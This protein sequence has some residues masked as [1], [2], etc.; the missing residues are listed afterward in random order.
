MSGWVWHREKTFNVD[1]LTV[2]RSACVSVYIGML[3]TIITSYK[4]TTNVHSY[5]LEYS[6]YPVDNA[7]Y[8]MMKFWE[9]LLTPAQ[10]VACL[11]APGLVK[12]F[13]D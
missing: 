7:Y 3:N 9:L 13:L 4:L 10:E 5:L 12:I 11:Y 8:T 1:S 6:Q 2:T